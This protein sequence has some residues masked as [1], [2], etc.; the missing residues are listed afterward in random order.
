MM[1]GDAV[2]R[3]MLWIA[4]YAASRHHSRRWEREGI[5]A[6]Q[7]MGGGPG[8][9]DATVLAG[10]VHATSPTR[11]TTVLRGNTSNTSNTSNTIFPAIV[12]AFESR[13]GIAAIRT[14]A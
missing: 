14:G 12:T 10:T 5:W 1:P 11:T 6:R 9:G 8:E 2:H 3:A 4:A 13:H 7:D